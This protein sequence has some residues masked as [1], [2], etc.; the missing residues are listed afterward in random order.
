[1]HRGGCD[2]TLLDKHPA[3]ARVINVRGVRVSGIGG[4]RRVKIRS[5][6]D[7][8]SIGPCDLVLIAVKSYDTEAA[9]QSALAL[10][11]TGTVFLTLQNGLGNVQK[12]ASIVG[13]ENVLAGTTAQ[14]ANLVS[15]GCI[16]HAGVGDTYIGEVSGR[17]SRR[18]R[19]VASLFTSCG[20]PA[21]ACKNINDLIWGKLVINAGINPLTVIFQ[22]RNGQL[23]KQ[24]ES[25]ELLRLLVEEAASVAR[26][27]GIRL[28]YRSAPAQAERV[29]SL[30]GE[31]VSSMLQ[32]IRRGKQTEIDYISGAIVREGKNCFFPTPLNQFALLVVRALEREAK[33]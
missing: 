24:R 21:K 30:T 7:A 20:I 19:S 10:L 1:L 2:V 11:G 32:D 17:L 5:T 23:L 33:H 9:T 28:P 26:K 18:A 12:I 4:R 15:P 22:C 25:R 27:K 29:A 6:A 31:N 14:G 16:V 8:S 13:E 3:R